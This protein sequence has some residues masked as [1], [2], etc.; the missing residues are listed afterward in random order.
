[1]NELPFLAQT[2]INNPAINDP[3]INDDVQQT[4]KTTKPLDSLTISGAEK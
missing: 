3:T 4:A 2:V 1:M